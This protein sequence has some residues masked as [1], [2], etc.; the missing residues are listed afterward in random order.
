MKTDRTYCAHKNLATYRGST[1][2]STSRESRFRYQLDDWTFDTPSHKDI[3]IKEQK[4]QIKLLTESLTAKSKEDDNKISTLTH[5][6][7]NDLTTVN[8]QIHSLTAMNQALQTENNQ[9]KEIIE[10]KD[11][12]ISQFEEV[13]KETAGKLGQLEA[14]KG[15][16][17]EVKMQMDGLFN[18]LLLSER[19]NDESKAKINQLNLFLDQMVN[20]KNDLIQRMNENHG[21]AMK[22]KE[23]L[24]NKCSYIENENQALLR[25]ND[26]LMNEVSKLRRYTSHCQKDK[27]NAFAINE[28]LQHQINEY[29][30]EMIKLR[31]KVKDYEIERKV[32]IMK[33]KDYEM[34]CWN[35]STNCN[36]Y[37]MTTQ[38]DVC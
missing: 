16:D 6:L 33:A 14:I 7:Y 12:L 21:R 13:A 37:V 2:P 17:S 27:D 35:Q 20:E 5:S 36:T 29:S 32:L 38:S 31:D 26:N 1:S 8:K 18:E 4:S 3:Q 24:F 28:R 9:L 30:K 25:Q 15:Q 23:E 19:R 11:I 22:D 34:H 10:K